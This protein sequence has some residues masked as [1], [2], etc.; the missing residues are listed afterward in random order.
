MIEVAAGC[1]F[2]PTDGSL[3]AL[4]LHPICAGRTEISAV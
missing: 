3:P 4:R 2:S 1:K